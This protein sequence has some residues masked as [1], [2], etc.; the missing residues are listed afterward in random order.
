MYII[1][2]NTIAPDFIGLLQFFPFETFF[3]Q[4]SLLPLYILRDGI[5]QRKAGNIQQ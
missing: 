3:G 1:I 2:H 4:C 5:I